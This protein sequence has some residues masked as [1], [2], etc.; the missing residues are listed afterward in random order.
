MEYTLILNDPLTSARYAYN[1][2]AKHWVDRPETETIRRKICISQFFFLPSLFFLISD[3]VHSCL[4]PHSLTTRSE[5]CFVFVHFMV[6]K[7]WLF[8]TWNPWKFEMNR[9][10][11]SFL[12]TKLKAI[13]SSWKLMVL[14]DIVENSLKL[15]F[16]W[17][18]K[19]NNSFYYYIKLKS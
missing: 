13:K 16:Y 18:L 2:P 12:F 11:Y 8:Q 7:H 4:W 14:E 5:K 10:L 19:W 3:V 9:Q 17:F 15:A 1:F 6:Y